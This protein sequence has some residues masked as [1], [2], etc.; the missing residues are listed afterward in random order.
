MAPLARAA[1]VLGFAPTDLA[2]Y[3]LYASGRVA[4]ANRSGRLTAKVT[5]ATKVAYFKLGR[6][7]A[8]SC[9]GPC[10]RG[11]LARG[12]RLC[13]RRTS[14]WSQV[15]EGPEG[16]GGLAR[17]EQRVVW[18][19]ASGAYYRT[20][21]ASARGPN[22][23]AG[24]AQSYRLTV[25]PSASVGLTGVK[26]MSSH[27]DLRTS[28]TGSRAGRRAAAAV[29]LLL[30][31]NLVAGC[32]ATPT[33]APTVAVETA[34]P[35]AAVVATPLGT[36]TRSPA[37]ATPTDTPVPTATPTSVPTPT[38]QPTPAPEVAIS[39]VAREVAD[40]AQAKTAATSINAFGLDFFRQLLADPALGL[41]TKNAVFSPASIALAL[42]MVRAGAKGETA[43]Q[44][45]AV[46]HTGG[47]D[48]LGS[49][50][51][52]LDQALAS[53][54]GTW[55][56]GE[57]QGELALRIANAAY[58]QRDFTIEQP[59]LDAIAAAFGAGLRLVDFAADPEAARQVIN[60][61]VSQQT[62]KRIPELLAPGFLEPLTRLVLVNAIYLK[63]EWANKFFEDETKLASFTRLDG[64]RVKVPTMSQQQAW[65]YAKG[66][67]WQATELP[68]Q[69]AEG[70]T[71]LA[72]TLILPDDLAT[73]EASLTASQ[74]AGITAKLGVERKRAGQEVACSSMCGCH[75]YDVALQ[76]PRFAIDTRASLKELLIALGMPLAFDSQG[77][78]FT[79]IHVPQSE[80]DNLFI[81]KGIHQA[82]VDVD[83]KGTEAAAATAFGMS[84]GGCTGTEALKTITLRLDRP[85]LFLIR[86]VATG[87]VLFIGQ[88][89]DPS[90]GKAG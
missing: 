73:F 81:S 86:D 9:R 21:E 75:R 90:V 34:G 70:S 42:G 46:L 45:D 18:R 57:G 53:R 37:T 1:G 62:K 14:L 74:L 64:S 40:P 67:G 78:D 66:T 51:N 79:G 17:A 52:A 54:N 15:A 6:R 4:F 88:V 80:M 27:D 33:T 35:S 20:R 89:T 49:G 50:L 87:A 26:A 31:S 32:G 84:T 71:P 68:Y 48:E 43:S 69:G 5:A 41:A 44:I 85:F 55:E 12:Y 83:E 47:W 82:N 24:T 77:A 76:L 16:S 2:H 23:A 7:F 58:G 11:P 36:P 25:P 8:P 59:Y 10:R 60:A 65:P 38:L 29:C 56:A 19:L 22:L 72:M 3:G 30:A 61:W 39:A 13:H 63:A 28:R